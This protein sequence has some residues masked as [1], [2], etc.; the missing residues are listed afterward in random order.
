LQRVVRA[1]FRPH[2]VLAGGNGSD[3]HGIALLEGR[4]LL[5]GEPAAYVCESLRCRQPVSRPEDLAAL[6]TR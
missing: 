1:T 5:D 6:L 2:V 4:G 3:A